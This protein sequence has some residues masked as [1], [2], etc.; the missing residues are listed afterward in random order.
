MFPLHK[1]LLRTIIMSGNNLQSYAN[2]LK[3][4]LGLQRNN[5]M[6]KSII[7]PGSQVLSDNNSTSSSS[8]TLGTNT[9][10]NNHS[11]SSSNINNITNHTSSGQQQFLTSKSSSA[12]NLH[13][14]GNSSS[15]VIPP[16]KPP[17]EIVPEFYHIYDEHQESMEFYKKAEKKLVDLKK[18]SLKMIEKEQEVASLFVDAAGR[19]KSNREL[20]DT[21]RKFGNNLKST[22][23]LLSQAVSIRSAMIEKRLWCENNPPI[24]VCEYT[25]MIQNVVIHGC[26]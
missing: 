18:T 4:K 14:N 19:L 8:T 1:R 15:S 7:V 21:L 22:S 17:I 9:S 25:D 24:C 16:L 6:E 2:K 20:S 12:L 11:T 23:T 10:T 5:S 13:S 26:C 3:T